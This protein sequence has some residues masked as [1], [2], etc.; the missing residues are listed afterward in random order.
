MMID[1]CS[2]NFVPFPGKT[3]IYTH[4]GAD[5][6]TAA[7]FVEVNLGEMNIL[8]PHTREMMGI[9]VW[10]GWILSPVVSQHLL[11]PISRS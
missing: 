5:W 9:C 4:D 1:G 2:R 10:V 8:G 11:V 6:R 3:V 7:M